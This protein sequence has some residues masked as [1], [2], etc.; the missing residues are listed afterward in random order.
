[1]P[2][3]KCALPRSKWWVHLTTRCYQRHFMWICRIREVLHNIW[4]FSKYKLYRS[5]RYSRYFIRRRI[6][7]RHNALHCQNASHWKQP[8]RRAASYIFAILP[9]F[10][11]QPVFNVWRLQPDLIAEILLHYRQLALLSLP[12]WAPASTA[13]CYYSAAFIPCFSLLLLT[14]NFYFIAIFTPCFISATEY[15]CPPHCHAIPLRFQL[16]SLLPPLIAS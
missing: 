3:V 5:F 11:T 9:V 12:T 4:R 6:L 14:T 7:Q 16:F 13:Y 15:R 8:V 1:M 10:I 2:V